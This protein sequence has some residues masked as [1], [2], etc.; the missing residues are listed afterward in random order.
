M[1]LIATAD[2][3]ERGFYQYVL[4]SFDFQSYSRMQAKHLAKNS[5]RGAL[6]YLDLPQWLESR[7]RYVTNLQLD[8][9][10]PLQILDIG[11]GPGHFGYICAYFGHKVIG[12]DQP[13]NDIFK[14]LVEQ[15]GLTRIVQAVR[16]A[17]PLPDMPRCDLVTAFHATFFRKPGGELF[18]LAEWRFFFDDLIR[19]R[20]TDQGRIHFILD[21]LENTSGLHVHDQAFINFI[22]QSGGRVRRQVVFFDDVRKCPSPWLL[23][24]KILESGDAKEIAE[25]IG[26][27]VDSGRSDLTAGLANEGCSILLSS[28]DPKITR[29][30]V[31]ALAKTGNIDLVDMTK[32]QE[33]EDASCI[34]DT[35]GVM[36]DSGRS[37]LAAKLADQTRDRLAASQDPRIIR[38]GISA[39]IEGKKIDAAADLERRSHEILNDDRLSRA[40]ANLRAL[41]K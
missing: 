18:N 41:Q 39:L 24:A 2:A 35:I 10:D 11:C 31:S 20:M 32:L 22:E 19:N 15:L 8:R 27:L 36:M 14:D 9:C 26:V 6:K 29:M 1:L 16:P 38:L 25:A 5:A 21:S 23:P 30:A 3:Q 28:G 34:A 12:L 4:D 37:D 40:L 17:T 7:Y 33:S 13:G